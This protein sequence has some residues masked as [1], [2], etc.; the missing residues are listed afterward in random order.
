MKKIIELIDIKNLLISTIIFVL[1]VSMLVVF[2]IIPTKEKIKSTRYKIDQLK[3]QIEVHNKLLP[4]YIQLKSNLKSLD[5]GIE[6]KSRK[7]SLMEFKD[8]I[9]NVSPKFNLNIISMSPKLKKKVLENGLIS[10]DLVLNGKF[11]D[12]I[13][14]IEYLIKEGYIS[15]IG[16]VNIESDVNKLKIDLTV[17]I[18]V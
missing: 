15:E 9:F 7:V 14:W 17:K 18:R 4:I 11:K 13:N 5:K 16:S 8:K 2:F 12:F 3:Q 6:I 1:L 10:L